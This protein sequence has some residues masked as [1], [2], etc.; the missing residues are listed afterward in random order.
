MDAIKP[1]LIGEH[2]IT[3]ID[4]LTAIALGSGSLP[5]YGTPALIALMETAAVAA[6]DPLLPTGQASV[7]IDIEMEHLAAT[8]P[9][10]PVRAEVTA[11]EGRT[12]SFLIQ[13]WDAHEQIG[14][15]THTRFVVDVERFMGRVN[16]KR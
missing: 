9:G 12:V 13:A 16:S 10:Q 5:V 4:D 3:V 7:G 8:P 6:I 1:G 11:V 14:E 2:T 15:G